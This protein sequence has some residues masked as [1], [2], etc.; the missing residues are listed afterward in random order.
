MTVALQI[1]DVPE[2]TRDALA[3]LAAARGQSMQAYLLNL[4]TDEVR[5]AR[6]AQAFDE[7]AAYRVAIPP[8]FD[9][10]AI[11]RHGRDGAG[12]SGCLGRDPGPAAGGVLISAQWELRHN[13][14]AYD[15]A[16]VVLAQRFAVPLLTTDPWLARA[17]TALGAEVRLVSATGPVT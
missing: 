15:A 10:D 4:V 11:I 17:A 6:N 13:V 3:S 14:S 12:R 16:Y 9:A 5:L 1:R 7:L 8:G 2:E